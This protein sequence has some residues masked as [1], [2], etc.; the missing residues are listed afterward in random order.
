MEGPFY[1]V[2]AKTLRG[3]SGAKI[4]RPG[5]FRCA[6]GEGH[7]WGRPGGQGGRRRGRAGGGGG[8]GKGPST[9]YAQPGELCEGMQLGTR[10]R[11]GAV[12]TTLLLLITHFIS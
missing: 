6:T 12:F 8:Q 4:T 7:R 2:F 5:A 3:L 10:G 9:L 11:C 1:D